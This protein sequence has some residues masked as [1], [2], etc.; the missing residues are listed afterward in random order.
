MTEEDIH[1][2]L[3]EGFEKNAPKI[4]SMTHLMMDMYEQGFK[5]CFKILTGKDF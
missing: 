5:D 2:V 3:R 4:D 1:R